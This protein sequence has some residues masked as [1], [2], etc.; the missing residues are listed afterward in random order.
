MKFSLQ[1]KVAIVTGGCSG[2]GKAITETF[3]Q[4]G[5]T[6][7]ILDMNEK[8]GRKLAKELKVKEDVVFYHK[9]DVTKQKTVDKV[10]KRIG[11]TNNGSAI[12]VVGVSL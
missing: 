7:H 5:A 10:L 1:N 9:C 3:V 12:S 8:L 6:V 4:M 11:S 2:I